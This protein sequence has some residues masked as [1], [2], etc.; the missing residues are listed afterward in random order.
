MYLRA[1][2]TPKTHLQH[3]RPVPQRP[4]RA[5][6]TAAFPAGKPGWPE[7][8]ACTTAA[9]GDGPGDWSPLK[10]YEGAWTDVGT[11]ARLQWLKSD[12]S[13]R[14]P[15]L[16]TVKH[17][18]MN[19]S[20]KPFHLRPGAVPP[21][22][23]KMGKDGRRH[24]PPRR[25]SS[26]ANR[27]KRLFIPRRQLLLLPDG[28][29]GAPTPRWSFRA[30][31]PM[32]PLA[33]CFCAP[34]R[35]GARNLGRL[36]PGALL[37]HRKCW[38]WMPRFSS[39]EL[40]AQAPQNCW[41]TAAWSGTP[42]AT[43]RGLENQSGWLAEQPARPCALWGDVP[44]PAARPVRHSG[45]RCACSRMPASRT[46][47]AAPRRLARVRTSAPCSCLQECC[48][49]GKNRCVNTIWMPSCCT[50]SACRARNLRLMVPSW[51]AGANALRA[52]LPGRRRTGARWRT[53]AD[54]RGLRAGR[55][56]P[57]TSPA[58]SPANGKI[59]RTAARAL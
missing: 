34:E 44:G 19:T 2:Q 12:F 24:H 40:D 53:R 22:A 54:R 47:C 1:T 25:P 11:P 14:H 3:H 30:M 36:P 17:P 51:A 26:R 13:A 50:N 10:R 57:A 4:V 41:I 32:D 55:L 43:H 28:L 35:Y 27:D 5:A 18:L 6:P 31:A 49:K 8:S 16:K 56:C 58:P 15:K 38:V 59:R 39:A 46:P 33:R 52:A 23:A 48:A 29:Q 42:F 37:P 21:L 45:T 9:R 7:S 20:M